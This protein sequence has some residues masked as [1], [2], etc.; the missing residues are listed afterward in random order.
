MKLKT[1]NFILL[2]LIL[3]TT[4]FCQIQDWKTLV[5]LESSRKEVEKILGKPDKYFET[6]GTYQ[7][8]RGEFSVWYSTGGCRKKVKGLQW[9]VPAQ[10]LT[11]ILMYTQS[12]LPL[13]AYIKNKDEYKKENS[14]DLSKN[15]FLY[16]SPDESIIYQTI[17]TH[18]KLEFV[19]TIE[20]QPGKNK[21]HLLCKQKN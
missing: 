18:D 7:T 11:R 6:Y 21:K 2:K 19:N 15:R 1:I 16:T 10:K 4:V 9:N 5:P 14:P 17:V 8:P 3:A 12:S 13:E 20:L